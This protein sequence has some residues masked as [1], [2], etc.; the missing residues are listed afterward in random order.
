[1]KV[2]LFVRFISTFRVF[3]TAFLGAGHAYYSTFSWLINCRSLG[4]AVTLSRCSTTDDDWLVV[5]IV[6]VLDEPENT[7]RT[8]N[9]LFKIVIVVN[10]TFSVNHPLLTQS[11]FQQEMNNL[12]VELQ[13]LTNT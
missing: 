9:S 2:Y 7:Q 13:C 12:Q 11:I 3:F 1:M 6:V 10:F 8:K 4:L 5:V